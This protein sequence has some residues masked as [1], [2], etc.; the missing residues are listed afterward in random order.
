MGLDTKLSCM[1]LIVTTLENAEEADLDWWLQV[2]HS[3]RIE[4]VESAKADWL[5]MSGETM[6]KQY[7]DFEDLFRCLNSAQANYL[8]I[9]GYAVSYHVG[10]RY[11]KD[12]DIWIEATNDNAQR[13]SDALTDFIGD[14]GL[15]LAQLT[16]PETLII[17]GI[18]PNRVDILT[19]LE[20]IAFRDAW[21]R[22]CQGSFRQ[23]PVPYLGLDDLIQAKQLAGRP[24]DLADLRPGEGNR[25]LPQCAF[26]KSH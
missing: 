22:R 15:T 14:L 19:H 6:P 2:P 25:S 23:E 24:Q 20:G 21:E 18:P 10:P 13:V 4:G 11:T 26:G 9:G 1:H 3:V 5:A 7:S 17:L 16:R 8:V 12:I